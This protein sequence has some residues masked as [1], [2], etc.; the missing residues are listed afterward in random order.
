LTLTK[1]VLLIPKVI[2]SLI[3]ELKQAMVS[4][5]FDT[6][7]K[8]IFSMICDLDADNN[9]VISFDEWVGLMTNKATATQSRDH[10][11]KVFK[12]FDN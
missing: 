4:L 1:A 12:L 6:K 11:R 7:N 3:Q 8:A 5:G 2:S 9:G 10:L